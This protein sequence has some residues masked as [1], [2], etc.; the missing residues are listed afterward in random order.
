MHQQIDIHRKAKLRKERR[1]R[2]IDYSQKDDNNDD[3]VLTDE[4][5]T[6][7]RR[8]RSSFALV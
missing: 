3:H 7:G 1:R 6:M 5:Q 8:D 4:A 2:L